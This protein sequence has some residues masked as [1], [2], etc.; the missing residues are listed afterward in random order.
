MATKS[1][2]KQINNI[3]H[4]FKSEKRMKIEDLDNIVIVYKKNSSWAKTEVY[5]QSESSNMKFITDI[6][7]KFIVGYENV[8]LKHILDDTELEEL[9]N[10]EDFNKELLNEDVEFNDDNLGRLVSENLTHMTAV[11]NSILGIFVKEENEKE[12]TKKK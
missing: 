11:V 7:R 8:K 12:E 4:G 5:A 1:Q 9:E 10:D 2:T 3:L 6:L